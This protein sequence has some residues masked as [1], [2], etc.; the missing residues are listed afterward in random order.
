MFTIKNILKKIVQPAA[1][2]MVLLS[3]TSCATIAGDNTRTVC[4]NSYPQG[5]GIFIEG[6]RHGTTPANVTLPNYIYG[7]KT[8]T[9]KKEGYYDQ[10]MTI[11]TKFQPC[12]LWNLLFWPGFVIDGAT[13]NTV[14]INPAQL[15]LTTEL[16]T[17]ESA[18]SK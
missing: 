5:A 4:V 15:N 8:M 9:L 10:A 2:S 1:V 3:L 16:Q 11:N 14:K 7:G 13:G 18:N 6:Q 17:V 12:G